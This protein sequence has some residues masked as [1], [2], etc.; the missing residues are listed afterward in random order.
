MRKLF[1]FQ[2][3][4]TYPSRQLND[5]RLQHP[6][7]RVHGTTAMAAERRRCL[8]IHHAFFVRRKNPNYYRSSVASITQPTQS[9]QTPF[10]P[11][12]RCQ[13]SRMPDSVRGAT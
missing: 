3:V 9:F 8:Q 10:R 7:S 13:D 4:A 2:I 12:F 5:R 1:G 6:H 11:L